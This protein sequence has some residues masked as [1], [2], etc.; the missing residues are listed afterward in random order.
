MKD[1]LEG[2]SRGTLLAVVRTH[3]VTGEPVGS[4]TISRQ[5]PESISPASIRNIML[6]LEED[7]W[8][9]QPHTSAGRVPT[10]KAYRY[11][12]G[13][14]D[15]SEPPAKS[16]ADLIMGELGNHLSGRSQHS[17]EEIFEKTSRVLSLVSNNLGVVIR[18]PA[19]KAILEHI[20]FS[21]LGDRRILVLLVSP[22]VPVLHRMIRVDFQINQPE[23]SAAA[24][25]LN[26]HFQGWELER[27]REELRARLAAERNT[28]DSLV[29]ALRQL[30]ERGMLAESSLADVFMDG[31]SNLVGRP[32]LA[33]PAQ[34]R[35]LIHALETKENLVRLL[36]EC[37][38][39]TLGVTDSSLQVVVGL[40][41]A[42]P[43]MR[44]FALIGT[45]FP[46]PGGTSG[47]MAVLGP[48]RM[49]YDR[50]IRAIGLI[51]RLFRD[52]AAN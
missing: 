14:F 5:W 19:D 22:G 39:T 44:N 13:Q 17:E 2:R 4:R 33:D 26:T 46:W 52:Q 42:G 12:A 25:Y 30:N 18:Q 11:Y 8:L 20:H 6:D 28:V 32:E 47:R 40:P 35:D 21:S 1:S 48:A 29:L 9:E 43:E 51:G 38:A 3:I 15:A 10:E 49:P 34:L 16:D 45:R 27:I 50:A 31:A 7:G 24:D 36:N 37:L 23:L 41:A